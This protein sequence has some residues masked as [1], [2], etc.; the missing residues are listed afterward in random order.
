MSVCDTHGTFSPESPSRL[1]F[2]DCSLNSC[3]AFK[4]WM[5]AGQRQV[6]VKG[7]VYSYNP[8]LKGRTPVPL[9][10]IPMRQR[11]NSASPGSSHSAHK[12]TW[13]HTSIYR[14]FAHT[15]A[16]MQVDTEWCTHLCTG[17]PRGHRSCKSLVSS[18]FTQ[19]VHTHTAYVGVPATLCTSR[20]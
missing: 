12:H 9:C 19:S 20:I 8:G 11:K 15:W 4:T 18:A 6:H 13:E 16:V 10:P 3:S 2:S 5:K 7:R 17:N 1:Y 14:C